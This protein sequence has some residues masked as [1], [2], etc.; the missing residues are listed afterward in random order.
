MSQSSKPPAS[1]RSIY[2]EPLAGEPWIDIPDAAALADWGK[3]QEIEYNQLHLRPT[4][5]GGLERTLLHRLSGRR[6]LS[7]PQKSAD[8]FY[9]LY[10]R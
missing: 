9:F 6:E 7:P 4:L 10:Q 8:F 1:I 5:A 3:A 2:P